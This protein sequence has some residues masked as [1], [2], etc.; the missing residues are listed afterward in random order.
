MTLERLPEAKLCRALEMIL[1]QVSWEII[2]DFW[3]KELCLWNIFKEYSGDGMQDE[4]NGS[5]D[6]KLLQYCFKISYRLNYC[7]FICQRDSG[8]AWANTGY[9][10]LVNV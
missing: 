1:F 2:K 7:I 4:K 6:K 9:V 10:Y 5:R 3:A 8:V